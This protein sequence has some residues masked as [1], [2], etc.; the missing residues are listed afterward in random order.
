MGPALSK[1]V[2]LVNWKT[3]TSITVF[4][5]RVDVMYPADKGK[6]KMTLDFAA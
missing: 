1:T 2:S 6:T 3:I 4:E 5:N